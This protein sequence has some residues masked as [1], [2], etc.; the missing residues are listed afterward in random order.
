MAK[1]LITGGAGFIGS[2]LV[3]AFLES[4]DDV[5]VLDNFSSGRQENLEGLEESIRVFEAD[6]TRLDGIRSAF[7]GVEY[8]FHEAAVPSVP[9]S[10]E[11]PELSHDANSRGTLNVLIAARDAGV[12]RVIYAASSSA[13]GESPTLP[14]IETMSPAPKSPYAADKLHGEYL[15]QVFNSGF[16]LETVALRY[17]NVFGPRQA[18]D[19][20]YAAAIPKFITRILGGL[21]PIVYGDGE[22]SRDFTHIDNVVAANVAAMTSAEAP[23][24][25]FNVGIGERI[26]INA[27]IQTIADV[28]ERPVTI[29]YQPPRKGDVL[30]SL[31]SI[32]KA[33]ELLGYEPKVDLRRGLERTIAWYREAANRNEEAR[34]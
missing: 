32:E 28:L 29:D 8:V 12:K 30:H 24:E 9:R 14:K 1:I 11:D 3:R 31:A 6:I 13:Y 18:P 25:V 4:G 15:C 20:D 7:D 21:S 2:N 26:T 5:S 33:G 27:L 16:G 10:M 34:S 22:Q 17:F 19:S 23:G